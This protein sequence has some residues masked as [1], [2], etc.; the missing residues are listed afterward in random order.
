MTS[1][2]VIPLPPE[3]AAVY[4]QV[5]NE[6]HSAVLCRR[7]SMTACIVAIGGFTTGYM[8][9]GMIFVILTWVFVAGDV[10]FK[11]RAVAIYDQHYQDLKTPPGGVNRV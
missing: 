10:Y 4:D 1:D 2:D 8:F 11:R 6:L 7:L 9:I 5:S 3:Y